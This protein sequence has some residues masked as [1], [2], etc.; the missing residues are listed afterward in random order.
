M[1]EG[2]YNTNFVHQNHG[3]FSQLAVVTLFVSLVTALTI[4]LFSSVL[5]KRESKI[6]ESRYA[7]ILML[8]E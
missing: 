3:M 2:A 4:H 1:Q 7:V 8:G 5:R 6:I